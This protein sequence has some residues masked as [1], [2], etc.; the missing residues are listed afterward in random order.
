MNYT[1]SMIES[2]ANQGPFT[3]DWESLSQYQPPEWYRRAKFGIFIHWGVYAVPAFGNEWYPRNMYL[4]ESPEYEHHIKTYGP[5]KEFG[6]KDFIPMFTADKFDPEAWA[7][8]FEAS[9]AKY[10]VPVAEHHDGFQMYASDLSHWN[11][12]EM[13]P[14]RNVMGE[15]F[16]AF[17]RHGLVSCC[18][19]HRIE[20]WFFMGGG[21][22][23]DSDIHEPLKKGDLYWPSV[24][25]YSQTGLYS[26]PEPTAEYMEDWLFRCCELVDRYR[27]KVVYFDWWIQQ[28]A[29]K[30]YLK[31]FAAY[32]YNRAAEWGEGVAINYK[33]DAFPLGCAVLDLERGQFADCQPFFWQTD[34]AIAKNSWGYTENND[35]KK[36]K[37]ILCDLVD[38][39]S[40]NGNMLLNVGPKPDG[41]ITKEDEAVLRA[42]GRWLSVNGEA[43]YD[44]HCWRLAAEGPTP[45]PDGQFTDGVDKVF[46]A[47]DIRFTAKL[48]RIYATVLSYPEDG[49]ICITSLADT[50]SDRPHFQGIVQSVKALG[51]DEP[52]SF[53]RD[54]EGLK[55]Q[56]KT[57]HSEEPVVFR[58]TVE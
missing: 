18:S 3:P 7:E 54:G 28:A 22:T 16:E 49:K 39:V 21:R 48:N 31:L 26:K 12:A 13:G 10:V 38:A 30:P 40:K 58:I 44:T 1:M 32:Y 19:S 34:T 52:I 35:F 50:L 42:I 17:D 6:Y 8:L 27:P 25:E 36:P 53:T 45:M 47:K 20:H 51:F 41:S 57:I 23:F 5:H 2:V 4:Q 9:G 11:A 46:T 55:F 43:I 56:T 14:K 15:L 29:L 37:D 33:H 24:T